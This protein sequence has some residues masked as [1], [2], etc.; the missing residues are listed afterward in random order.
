LGSTDDTK[1]VVTKLDAARRQLKTAIKLWFEDGD[2][3][4]VHTL[5]AA[6]YEI[7][8][9]LAQRSSAVDL[10][11]APN[12][13]NDDHRIK[14]LRAIKSPANFFKH[15]DRDPDGTLEFPFIANEMFMFFSCIALEKMGK[16]VGME[17]TAMLFYFMLSNPDLIREDA[18][19]NIPSEVFDEFNSV[20]K[21]DFLNQFSIAWGRGHVKGT[22]T[23][24]S[25]SIQ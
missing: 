16:T 11:Y 1:I 8:D 23:F 7:L 14:W 18:R 19:K 9:T 3:V 17:E 21:R 6:A 4:A 24:D 5:I 12:I 2:P 25:E 22:F 20:T 15:A 10:L 13:I